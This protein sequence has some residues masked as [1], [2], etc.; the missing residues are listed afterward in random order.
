MTLTIETAGA[1]T[2]RHWLPLGEDWLAV[3]LG[4]LSVALVLA[5]V[6]PTLPAFVWASAADL[7]GTVFGPQNLAHMLIAGVMLGILASAGVLLMKESFARF[8]I[9][10]PALFALACAAL[11]IAGNTTISAWGF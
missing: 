10:F 7:T 9:A 5:G 6:R 11:V 8:V 4:G 3:W 1:T 2:R